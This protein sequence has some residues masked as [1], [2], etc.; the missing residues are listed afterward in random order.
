MTLLDIIVLM[1]LLVK[2]LRRPGLNSIIEQCHGRKGQV[3]EDGPK[4]VQ[5]I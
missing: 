4:F 5:E 1:P 3:G 2:H